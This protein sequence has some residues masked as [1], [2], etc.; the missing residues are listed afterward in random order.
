MPRLNVDLSV[1]DYD[2]ELFAERRI[3]LELR[4][5]EGFQHILL[6]II[7][8]ALFHHPRL[9]I[10]PTMDDDDRYKPDLLIRSEDYRPEVWIECGQVRVQKLDKVTFR[11]YYA[12]VVVIKRTEREA[13][14]LLERCR[15]EVR[16]L[17][18]IEFIGF[19]NGFIDRVADTL[20]GKNDVIAILSGKGMQL[21]VGG[22]TF[23]TGI[24]RYRL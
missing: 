16:R 7:A 5:G 23:E 2:R 19:D 6:K 17:E 22:S 8:M 11:H 14:E 24:H 15:G 9:Q 3:V 18:A 1:N 4:E 13:R 10:E 21:V 20:T 12:R